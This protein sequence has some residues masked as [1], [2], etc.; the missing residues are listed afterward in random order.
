MPSSIKDLP[1]YCEELGEVLQPDANL[2]SSHLQGMEDISESMLAR[3]DELTTMLEALRVQSEEQ[4]VELE[5]SLTALVQ[6]L[7]RDYAHVDET[8]AATLNMREAVEHMENE[9]ANAEALVGRQNNMALFA[10]S[11]TSMF[12]QMASSTYAWTKNMTA[13]D[14]KAGE[15]KPVVME[16]TQATPPE[17]KPE[18]AREEKKLEEDTHSPAVTPSS[19][20][21]SGAPKD[22]HEGEAEEDE[23]EEAKEGEWYEDKVPEEVPEKSAPQPPAEE[24]NS[25]FFGIKFW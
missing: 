3:L 6:G 7:E 10:A 1:N 16:D 21:P 13:G 9:I 23:E 8:V 25:G 14:G 12:K 15:T 4:R 11:T 24:E 22:F 2:Y 20:A 19:Q 5:P 17:L 18:V